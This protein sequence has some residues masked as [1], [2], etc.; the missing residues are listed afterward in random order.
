M[1]ADPNNAKSIVDD[2]ES[3]ITSI[4]EAHTHRFDPHAFSCTRLVDILTRLTRALAPHPL[5]CQAISR[6]YQELDLYLR[7]SHGER[8]L[9]ILGP[10]VKRLQ[11]KPLLV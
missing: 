6:Q 5:A 11:H 1:T 9:E 7:Q 10:N 8:D 2:P 4:V 3:P